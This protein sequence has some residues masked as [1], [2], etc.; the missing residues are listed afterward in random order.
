[1]SFR[2][3]IDDPRR[4]FLVRALAAGLFAAGGS[5]GILQPAFAMGKVP[6]ELVPGKSVYDVEGRAL[7]NG[8]QATLDTSI[9]PNASLETGPGGR[10]IFAVGR[11]A[12]ILRGNSKLKLAGSNTVV[13]TLNLLS[14]KLLSVFGKTQHTVQTTVA[15]VGIH[16]TDEKISVDSFEQ[17]VE[18]AKEM[19]EG[20]G[21]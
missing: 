11:D 6:K 21:Q 9:P 19:L 5:A 8:K 16:G 12:F 13:D 2:D 1:M 20:A 15:T 17:A 10:L 3:E 4:E 14:G 7:V 18:V